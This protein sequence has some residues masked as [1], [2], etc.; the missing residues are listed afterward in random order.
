MSKTK[1]KVLTEVQKRILAFKQGYKC[2]GSLCKGKRLLPQ[3]WEIDHIIPLHKGGTNLWTNLSVKCPNCHA[4][5]TQLEMIKLNRQRKKKKR[6]FVSPYFN[7]HHP[8]F[9]G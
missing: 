1:R 3:T 5:K 4:I 7:R 6:T 2:T 9:I 8:K